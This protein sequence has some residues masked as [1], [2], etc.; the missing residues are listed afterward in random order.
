MGKKPLL[1][2][3]TRKARK[4]TFTV[5]SVQKYAARIKIGEQVRINTYKC[6][7]EFMG[8]K[9]EVPRTATVIGVCGRIVRLM[10]PSGVEDD[11]SLKDYAL[12]RQGGG[13]EGKV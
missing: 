7:D 10:L 1:Y 5:G 8:Q 13:R 9:K 6:T 4:V 11:I 12:I 3:E 2:G